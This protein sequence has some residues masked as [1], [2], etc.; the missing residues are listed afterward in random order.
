[1]FEEFEDPDVDSVDLPNMAILQETTPVVCCDGST[2]CLSTG[3][4][5]SR[6]RCSLRRDGGCPDE[7]ECW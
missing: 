4:C 1:M 5:E 7:E 6:C 3:N 2:I